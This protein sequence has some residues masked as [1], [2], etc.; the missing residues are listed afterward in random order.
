MFSLTRQERCV[1]LFIIAAG[2]ISLGFDLYK[3]RCSPFLEITYAHNEPLKVN[4]NSADKESLMGLRGIGETIAQR[5]IDYRQKYGKFSSE[6]ELKQV[7]GINDYRYDKL[8]GSI[9]V[10]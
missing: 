3:K 7:K 9:T 8:K 4:I 10:K 2:L 5:I 6:E 1:L